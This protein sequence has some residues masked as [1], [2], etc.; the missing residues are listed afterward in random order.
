MNKHIEKI[1]V[2][3]VITCSV[4]ISSQAFADDPAS[5]QPEFPKIT[6]QPEDQ[7]ARLGSNVTFTVATENG[8]SYQWFRN[9][10]VIEGQTNSTLTIEGAGVADVGYYTCGV[11]KDG[12]IVPTRS[13]SLNVLMGGGGGTITVFGFPVFSGGS[14]G[15]CPGP[16]AGYVNYTKTV[17]QGWGWAPSTG[18]TVHTATDTNRT[19]TK[20]QYLGKFG[21]KNCQ[22]TTVTVPDPTF[23]PKYR[24]TIYFTNNVP[25]NSYAITLSGFDP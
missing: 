22:Q 6:R 18:T 23:S 16:Y 25:T 14:Q 13:A 4:I 19:D 21:D 24:F 20:V 12:E 5:D 11:V 8:D 10:V 3:I 1:M 7:A 2:S 17:V 15:T 9:G